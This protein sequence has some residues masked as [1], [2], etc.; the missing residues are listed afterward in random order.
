MHELPVDAQHHVR[1][2]LIL[3]RGAAGGRRLA[4]GDVIEGK[5]AE[6]FVG[7]PGLGGIRDDR[8]CVKKVRVWSA[9]ERLGSL[10]PALDAELTGGQRVHTN[11]SHTS[12]SSRSPP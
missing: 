9:C 8:L 3:H 11:A 2:G 12:P 6:A 1:L 7:M 10:K 5:R 4:A